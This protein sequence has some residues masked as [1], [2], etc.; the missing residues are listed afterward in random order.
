MG[1]YRRFQPNGSPLRLGE[2]RQKSLQSLGTAVG[3][4]LLCLLVEDKRTHGEQE[5]RVLHQ[6]EK[7]LG[8]LLEA[9]HRSCELGAHGRIDARQELR[10]TRDMREEIDKGG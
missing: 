7:R 2:N 3:H 9:R 4:D 6:I 1:L 10:P 8:A 5:L